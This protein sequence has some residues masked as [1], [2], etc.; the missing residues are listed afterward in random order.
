MPV[1]SEVQSQSE[2]KTIQNLADTLA[3]QQPTPPRSNLLRA[4]GALPSFAHAVKTRSN[5]FQLIN[6]F[7]PLSK[8]ESDSLTEHTHVL[9]DPKTQTGPGLDFFSIDF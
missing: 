7:A 3:A 9:Y 6:P 1:K 2:S 4:N 8:D 5:P